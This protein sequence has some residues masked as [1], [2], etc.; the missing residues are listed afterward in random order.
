M[1]SNA[2]RAQASWHPL[3]TK[4]S[5]FGICPQLTT[6]NPPKFAFQGQRVR[7]MHVYDFLVYLLRREGSVNYTPDAA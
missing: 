5:V 6:I 1:V 3:Q 7:E 4:R 2:A